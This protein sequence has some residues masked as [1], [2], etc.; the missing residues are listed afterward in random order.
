MSTKTQKLKVPQTLLDQ[1]SGQPEIQQFFQE[2]ENRDLI[3]E[4]YDELSAV[5]TADSVVATVGTIT[6]GAVVDTRTINSTYLVVNES[7]KFEIDFTFTGLEGDPARIDFVGRYEGNIG[8]VVSAQI[9]NYTTL[10]FDN[11]VAGASDFPSRVTDYTLS[12]TYPTDSSDYISGGESI[13]RIY[14]SSPPNAA[15][16]F[17]TDFISLTHKSVSLP[18]AGT[19]VKL[20]DISDGHCYRMNCSGAA[21]TIGA[22]TVGNYSVACSLSFSGTA[23]V[24]ILGHIYVNGVLEEH[25]GFS[26]QLGASGD[27][28][29]AS[30]AGYVELNDGDVV[31]V[32][33]ASSSDDVYVSIEHF[34]LVLR[35]IN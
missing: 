25:I 4:I 14:H 10:G 27:V 30:M 18:V 26:R 2:L 9:Y 1:Y 7:G 6:S 17:Y 11:M 23:D 33:L 21:G 3:G 34:N 15:H 35:A 31:D 16:N 29:S 20:T 5:H 8:H 12:F 19:F 28:G 13:F 24:K 32:R 22:K